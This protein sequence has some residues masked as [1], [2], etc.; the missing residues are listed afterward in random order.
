[1]PPRD[2]AALV[3]AALG[4]ELA[5]LR[6]ALAVSVERLDGRRV[7]RARGTELSLVFA[8]T[9]D[10]PSNAASRAARLCERYRP[11]VLVGIG[12]A[13]AITPNLAPLDLVV[14]SKLRN[15]SG[16]GPRAD[17]ILL[18]RATAGGALPA[19]LVT[20]VT[21]VVSVAAKRA[22]AAPGEDAA[23]VDMESSAWAKAATAAGVP[24]VVVRGIADAADEELPE[25]LPRCLGA[26]G[27]I[28]RS[29]VVARALAR[30]GTFPALWKLR[31]RV[32]ECAERLSA[33]LL[34]RFFSR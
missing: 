6:R 8:S 9:G 31:R 23:A 1:M 21:P 16:E 24:F 20:T 22:L 13:G 7:F 5:P 10:G 3:V 15:G 34:D 17:E 32:S 14:S 11:A 29:A 25:Y 4:E 30:P 12:V 18:R 33:F 27:G 26:D 2:V 28:R 19:T